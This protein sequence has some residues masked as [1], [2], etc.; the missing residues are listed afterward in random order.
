MFCKH[1]AHEIPENAT[2]CPSC[3]QS[4]CAETE[5]ARAHKSNL[6]L[7]T[8]L[9]GI[10]G[11]AVTWQVNMIL[12]IIFS[13]ISLVKARQ[14]TKTYGTPSSLVCVGKTLSIMA[15]IVGAVTY[16]TSLVA[17]TIV[18]VLYIGILVLYIGILVLCAVAGIGM[19]V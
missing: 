18:L 17:L 9:W 6:A 1:C 10:G 7:S 2:D 11:I 15:I 12:G 5:T 3:G 16:V 19:A 8:M 13:I 4:V 14:F